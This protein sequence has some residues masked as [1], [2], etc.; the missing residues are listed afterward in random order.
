MPKKFKGG[1]IAS[2]MVNSLVDK[3]CLIDKNNLV[4]DVKTSGNSDLLSKT[5]GVLYN[6]TGGKKKSKKMKGGLSLTPSLMKG[7]PVPW[8]SKTYDWF[9]GN[10]SNQ[11]KTFPIENPISQDFNKSVDYVPPGKNEPLLNDIAKTM[12]GGKKQNKKSKNKKMKGSGSDWVST[13]YSRGSY[14]APNM[15]L[16]QFKQFNTLSKYISNIELANGAADEF[17]STEAV[18]IPHNNKIFKEPV[19]FN[20]LNGVP[21]KSFKGGKKT[22]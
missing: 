11:T 3:N 21:T 22:K 20:Q 16:D 1:S 15:P 8:T 12:A 5:Y 7:I 18:N 14:T 13:V 10:K 17:K 19:A 6:T 4:N 2:D 9:M